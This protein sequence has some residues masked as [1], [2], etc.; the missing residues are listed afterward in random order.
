MSKL[1]NIK[2]YSFNVK[3]AI[4][5]FALALFLLTI[6]FALIVPKMQEEQYNRAIDE[7]EKVLIITEEQVR[8]AGKA[9]VMQSKLEI[10]LNQKKLELELLKLKDKYKNSS[11]TNALIR[12]IEYSKITKLSNYAIKSEN[13]L[14]VNDKKDI[15]DEYKLI[16]YNHWE[17]HNLKD[18]SRN[19]VY[20]KKYYFYTIKINKD[21]DVTLFSKK[22]TL[23]KGHAPFEKDVKIN[24]QKAF[25]T[26]QEL[27]KGKTYLMWLNS[28]Y[29]NED[30]KP[31]YIE[32]KILK[33]EKYTISNMS[34]VDNI[35]TGNLSAKELLDAKNKKF[36]THLLNGKEAI[37]WVRDLSDRGEKDY[38]F[39]LVKT[40]YKEDINKQVD[41]AFFKI[42]PAAIIS[43]LV[44]IAI[45]FLIFKRLFKSINTLTTTAKQ[46][47]QGNRSIRSNVSGNDDIGE[48]GIAFDTMINN[49]ENSIKVL[50]EKVDEKT[51]ELSSS[52]E[53]KEI[54]LKEIHHRVKNN[55]ALTISLIKLQQAKI[56]DSNTKKILKDIQERIY[57]MELLHRKLY[58]S[59]NLNSINLKE[60]ITNLTEDIS[61]TYNYENEVSI[62]INMQDIYLNI[63]TAMPCGLILNEII[64]NA[65]KYAFK[66]HTNPKLQ[67][68]MFEK[69][70][71]YELIIKDNGNGIDENINIYTSSSLGLKL[72]NSICK[73][74]L[75]GDL[76]Y[77]Y[78]KGAQF[79]IK[80]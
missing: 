43:L 36:V 12:D 73:L 68:D 34:N 32:D 11:D 28:K 13:D 71:S 46:I 35:Y 52:L 40:L 19:Y 5:L 25:N 39:L 27:H 3:V 59:T 65:F 76:Q 8:V 18:L 66:D 23:N 58:E 30:D 79:K 44:A 60:Y 56:Q 16:K 55:L 17:I 9:I 14:Y 6:L 4:S 57:T 41:S 10:E 69:E 22:G 78:E 29:K 7:I 38:I 67:I 48:L 62:Q 74:Q 42:L 37:T 20:Y 64:T 21:I 2:S 15:Y 53:E 24:V 70:G 1:L 50:D 75:H 33:R 45:G 26:T 61:N 72:I 49:F 51:K 47:N 77:T 31:L 63:E 54:L 80:F